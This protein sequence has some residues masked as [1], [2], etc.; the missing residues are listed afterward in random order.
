MEGYFS[1]PVASGLLAVRG[2]LCDLLILELDQMRRFTYPLP[3]PNIA[4]Y[5]FAVTLPL[6]LAVAIGEPAACAI[7]VS[8][9]AQLG[10]DPPYSEGPGWGGGAIFPLASC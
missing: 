7:T 1:S 4:G 8:G 3:H 9:G 6:C 10:A 5:L 2:I